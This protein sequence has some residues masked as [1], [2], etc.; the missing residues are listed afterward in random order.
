V[1]VANPVD[2]PVSG[3][4]IGQLA[5]DFIVP[6]LTHAGPSFQLHR[7]LGRPI[8]LVFYQPNSPTCRELLGFCEELAARHGKE[9]ALFALSLDDD[10][11]RVRKQ[12]TE[13]KLS[14]PV[15]NGSALR[16]T[17]QLETTPKV[18]VLAPTG[19]VR[20]AFLGWGRETPIAVSREVQECL[21]SR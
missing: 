17:Y 8:V 3:A 4:E 21:K 18:F 13:L 7:W 11:G 15:L 5:P 1:R 19:V 6:F 12:W 14:I 16:K 20:G 9:I 10:A 2:K